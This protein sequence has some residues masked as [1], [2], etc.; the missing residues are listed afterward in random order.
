LHKI[1]KPLVYFPLIPMTWAVD[2]CHWIRNIS[3]SIIVFWIRMQLG[4]WITKKLI[5]ATLKQN[6]LIFV[7]KC[8]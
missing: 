2:L 5:H 1:P 8:W 6:E 4:L 3:L 7:L